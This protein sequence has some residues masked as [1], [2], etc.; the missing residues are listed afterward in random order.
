MVFKVEE[1][2]KVADLIIILLTLSF[3]PNSHVANSW[4]KRRHIF[5]ASIFFF[6]SKVICSKQG[7]DRTTILHE[8][9]IPSSPFSHLN[10]NPN[11]AVKEFEQRPSKCHHAINTMFV[12][13][14][15][16]RRKGKPMGCL[17]SSLWQTKTCPGRACLDISK[18]PYWQNVG[19]NSL[20]GPWDLLHSDL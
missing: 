9:G 17:P 2:F 18:C 15:T 14:A 6:L 1:L 16:Y 10:T 11:H 7:I 20:E 3:L 5:F 13:V 19:L 8:K 12:F 4:Y